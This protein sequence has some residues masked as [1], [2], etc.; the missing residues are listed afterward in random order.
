MKTL[1]ELQSECARLGVTV[2]A[3][4]RPSKAPYIR[5]LREFHWRREHADCPP[6]PQIE[7][8]LLSDWEDLRPD[9]AKQL[10]ADR[11][12]WIVQAKMDGVRALLHVNDSGIRITGRCLN[13]VT[14]RL[15]EYQANRVHL[16]RGL[17]AIS[18]TILDGELVCPLAELNTGG[19][20]TT[21][22]LQAA[23]AVLATSPENAA[24][25]QQEDAK[26]RLHVFDILRYRNRNV[27]GMT[28]ADG[29]QFLEEA[30]ASINNR[31]INIVPYI[32]AD[33][34]SAHDRIIEQGGE[35]TVWK[36]ASGIHEPGPRV[37]HWIKRKRS[38]QMEAFVIGFKRG[39][40]GRGNEHLIG[41]IAFSL[42]RENGV[43]Q[44]IAWIS[45]WTNQEREAMTWKDRDGNP[46]LN[47][48]C[49]ERRAIIA[50]QDIAGRSKRLR[51]A[52]LTHWVD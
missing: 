25:I 52:R 33:R 16:T 40:P 51:H 29:L 26:L 18:G 12:D 23:V 19:T 31:Y 48:T 24:Q 49:Y 37:K 43:S 39:T 1:A 2:E 30:V 35:G 22:P 10:D 38:V 50:G 17:N 20:V 28:L 44:P 41:A 27:T 47:P 21:S 6:P 34:R 9:L 5:A 32:T 36:Y 15:S 8:M 3:H 11:H 46:A 45:S 7:P 4:G 13:E 42:G 14:Y